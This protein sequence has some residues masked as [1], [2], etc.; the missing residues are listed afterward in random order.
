MKLSLSTIE[1]CQCI[2][3]CINVCTLR[4]QQ[5]TTRAPDDSHVGNQ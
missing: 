2:Y 5:L 1:V 4:L 3:Y